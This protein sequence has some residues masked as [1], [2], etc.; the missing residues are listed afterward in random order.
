MFV[1][2]CNMIAFTDEHQELRMSSLRRSCHRDPV[3]IGPTQD[4]ISPAQA[5]TLILL[6]RD[7]LGLPNALEITITQ[8]SHHYASPPQH[9]TLCV[10]FDPHSK[11]FDH[12]SIMAPLELVSALD[13]LLACKLRWGSLHAA[14]SWRRREHR[15]P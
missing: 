14:K 5:E 10:W 15:Q 7:V 9:E 12:L 4:P 11:R 2:Y 6:L 13:V 3:Y 1:C 8:W